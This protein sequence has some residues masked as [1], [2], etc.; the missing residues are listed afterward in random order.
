LSEV[1][2]RNHF[3]NGS[4][5]K[6][7]GGEQRPQIALFLAP[8]NPATAI[9]LFNERENQLL[10]PVEEYASVALEALP[11]NCHRTGQR[12]QFLFV[13]NDLQVLEK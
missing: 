6:A 3:G 9:L 7:E 13:R 11:L 1:Y 2:V 8:T 12:L 5:R 4:G 10:A